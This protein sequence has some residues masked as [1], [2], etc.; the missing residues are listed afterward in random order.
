MPLTGTMNGRIIGCLRNGQLSGFAVWDGCPG[1]VSVSALVGPGMTAEVGPT[2]RHTALGN[3]SPI[4]FETL[5]T[6]ADAAA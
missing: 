2:R 3:L 6:A 5:R 1:G 4:E